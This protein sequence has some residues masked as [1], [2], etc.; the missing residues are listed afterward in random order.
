MKMSQ[1]R[2]WPI[3]KV[4]VQTASDTSIQKTGKGIQPKGQK[5][6]GRFAWRKTSKAINSFWLMVFPE[7]FEHKVVVG[8]NVTLTCVESKAPNQTMSDY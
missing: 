2:T 7:I 3:A 4:M 5:R 6:K 1:G 8:K